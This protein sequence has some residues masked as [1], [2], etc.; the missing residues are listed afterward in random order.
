MVTT[1][2]RTSN[3][4]GGGMADDQVDTREMTRALQQRMNDM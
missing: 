3:A 1:R 2:N 4:Y